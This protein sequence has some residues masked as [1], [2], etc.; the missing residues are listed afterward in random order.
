M[1]VAASGRGA[2]DAPVENHDQEVSEGVNTGSRGAIINLV[3]QSL[4]PVI[5]LLADTHGLP[6]PTLRPVAD[7]RRHEAMC[8]AG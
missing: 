1:I 5:A 2:R 3:N 6:Q 7:C 8:D 4:E